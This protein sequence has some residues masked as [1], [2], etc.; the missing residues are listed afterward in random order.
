M[1]H[2]NNIHCLKNNHCK[3]CLPQIFFFQVRDA[4]FKNIVLLEYSS[5]KVKDDKLCDKFLGQKFSSRIHSI[6]EQG[7]SNIELRW[8]AGVIYGDTNYHSDTVDFSMQSKL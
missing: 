5:S 3:K 7:Y 1:E 2:C 6:E 4:T 8:P